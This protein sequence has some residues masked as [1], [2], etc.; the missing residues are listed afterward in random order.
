MKAKKILIV[1]DAPDNLF[2]TGKI[3][4]SIGY[5]TCTAESG[6]DA[7][8]LFE[9]E[10]PWLILMDCNLPGLSGFEA[11]KKIR[12]LEKD[13]AENYQVPIIALTAHSSDDIYQ[14]CLESG[15]NDRL[16]KPID[17]NKLKSILEHF[18][19]ISA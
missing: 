7:I 8:S 13:R 9:N 5:E 12:Q 3:L 4:Q 14:Q 10:H 15:M 18:S 2:I 19:N 11:S 16:V 6:L 17:I 1:D